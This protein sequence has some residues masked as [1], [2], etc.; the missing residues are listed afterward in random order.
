MFKSLVRLSCLLICSAFLQPAP[1]LAKVSHPEATETVKNLAVSTVK[2]FS[3]QMDMTAAVP[4]PAKA[5]NEENPDIYFSAD[6]VE[7]NQEL[8]TITA[9]GNVEIIRNN[10]TLKAD[11][12][13]YNQKE[14]IITAVGN[15]VLVEENG[16]V[17]FSDYVELTDKMTQGEMKNIK[18]IM[19]DKTR[20]AASTFRR[21]AK[22]KK[23][24]TNV[25]YS[26]CDA[27]RN[28]NPLW[29][30]KARKVEHNAETQDI[31]YQNATVEIKGVP[32]LYTPFLSHPDPTVKRRSGFL[33]PKLSSNSYLGAANPA[34]ILLEH[35][36]PGRRFVQPYS[37][38]R[39]RHCLHPG[40]FNKYFYRGD[41]NASG[42]TMRDPDTKKNR[43]SLFLDGGTKS[44]TS[45][46]PAVK[47][48]TLPTVLI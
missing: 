32:V 23:I 3:P 20:I 11:K 42:T 30:I 28:E 12:V 27:C 40:A 4:A 34:A 48:T 14:D 9:L 19:L 29:Q 10:L 31:N 35:L 22:D 21:G 33:F 6:A 17:V 39:Q 46:L 43:G 24:M 5:I 47:S 37:D 16:S 2:G 26:P 18:I 36:R 1:V 44:T 13:I 38:Q 25:V 45:G 15:V 41:I 8:Q 7:N